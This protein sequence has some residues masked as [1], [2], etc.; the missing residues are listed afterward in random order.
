MTQGQATKIKKKKGPVL[1]R[2]A[3]ARQR[4]GIIRLGGLTPDK[5][6]YRKLARKQTLP[7]QDRTR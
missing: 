3:Q 2:A 5:L 7:A 1:K 6:D 4:T